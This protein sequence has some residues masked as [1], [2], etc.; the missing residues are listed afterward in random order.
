MKV[1]SARNY[2]VLAVSQ[3]W[4]LLMIKRFAFDRH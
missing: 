4:I 2:A 1:N 3:T